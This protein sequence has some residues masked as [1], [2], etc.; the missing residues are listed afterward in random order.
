[1]CFINHLLC[2]RHRGR[3]FTSVILFN[4]HDNPEVFTVVQGHT[5]SQWQRQD[6]GPGLPGSKVLV[7]SVLLQCLPWKTGKRRMLVLWGHLLVLALCLMEL[8]Q[9]FEDELL[10]LEDPLP[11]PSDGPIISTVCCSSLVARQRSWNTD[12]EGNRN[13]SHSLRH[14]FVHSCTVFHWALLFCTPEFPGQLWPSLFLLTF[15]LS[16]QGWENLMKR[17]QRSYV[18]DERKISYFRVAC[19]L[20]WDFN[21]LNNNSKMTCLANYLVCPRIITWL[22]PKSVKLT[23]IR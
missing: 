10:L 8:V 5:V 21:I 17:Q 19:F 7:L 12:G 9:L 3:H 13:V 2:A 14:S 16:V 20:K 11:G 4:L 15:F 6:V 23:A 18:H 1:M 22:N